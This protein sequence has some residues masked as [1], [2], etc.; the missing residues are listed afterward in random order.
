MSDYPSP[1]SL[2]HSPASSPYWYRLSPLDILMFRDAKPFAPGQRAWASGQFPPSGHAIAGALR[3]LLTQGANTPLPLRLTGPFFGHGDRG[4]EVLYLPRPLGYMGDHPLAPL[5]WLVDSPL[6]KHGHWDRRLPAPLMRIGGDQD[7]YDRDQD[8]QFRQFLPLF[9]VQAYL[10]SGRLEREQLLRPD[11]EP[12]QPWIEEIRAHNAIAPGTRQV[13]DADGYFVETAVRLMPGWS[14]AIGVDAATHQALTHLGDGLVLHLGG[15]G[16]RA[17][18]QRAEMLDKAWATLQQ[19]SEQNFQQGGRAIAYLVTPGVFERKRRITS[20][21]IPKATCQAWPWEWKL[22]P[23]RGDRQP[24]HQQNANSPGDNQPDSVL[25]GVATAKPQAIAGRV[26]DQ[27]NPRSSV[28]GPQVFAAVPGSQYY[29][30]QP[31]RLFQEQ[32][33]APAKVKRWRS[34]GY[35]ELLWVAYS[36]HQTGGAPT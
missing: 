7:N 18:L 29:L 10:Q 28:P 27:D 13:K 21:S 35:S 15:E 14:I 4:H 22:V 2:P 12:E 5:P 19:Q 33:D 16:H 11:Q 1:T 6:A 25:V 34:L 23:Y 36:G 32:D 20:R 9:V 26:R 3:S 17:L 24:S 31:Q 30:E 8:S